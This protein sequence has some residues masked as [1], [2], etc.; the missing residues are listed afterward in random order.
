MAPH[1]I[2]PTK[3]YWIL[4]IE[5]G[6]VRGVIWRHG[7]RE[8]TGFWWQTFKEGNLSEER[9]DMGKYCTFP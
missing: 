5:E 9:V 7:R 4:H 3:Y 2:L 8:N 6:E 1:F